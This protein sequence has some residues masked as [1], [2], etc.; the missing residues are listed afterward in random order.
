MLGVPAPKLM[1]LIRMGAKVVNFLGFSRR[2]KSG[3]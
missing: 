3:G 1:A 2:E